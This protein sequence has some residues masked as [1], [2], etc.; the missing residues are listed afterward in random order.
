MAATA[1]AASGV[2]FDCGESV[3]VTNRFCESF[4][5]SGRPCPTA[6]IAEAVSPDLRRMH[7]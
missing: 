4:P 3:G 1:M 6:A 5:R 2:C 7:R